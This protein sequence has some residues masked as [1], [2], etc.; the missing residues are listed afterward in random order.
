MLLHALLLPKGLFLPFH[1]RPFWPEFVRRARL[2]RRS[3]PENDGQSSGF[4]RP[5]VS[6]QRKN[7]NP[8]RVLLEGGGGF[9][10]FRR[11]YYYISWHQ[12]MCRIAHSVLK[13]RL[14]ARSVVTFITKRAGLLRPQRSVRCFGGRRLWRGPSA[15]EIASFRC[16]KGRAACDAGYGLRRTLFY[17]VGSIA[18]PRICQEPRIFVSYNT[19]CF[20]TLTSQT[21][22]DT[23]DTYKNSDRLWS[24]DIH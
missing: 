6:S 16:Y 8:P 2:S 14:G 7:P 17:E 10:F 18:L 1:R 11:D 24:L 12:C 21:I 9:E 13:H 3:C 22:L 5:R 19:Q 23:L 4:P 15:S 20:T